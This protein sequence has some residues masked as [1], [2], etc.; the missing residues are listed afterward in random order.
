VIFGPDG[1][2]VLDF[3]ISSIADTTSLTNTGAFVGTV[4]WISPEQIDS[5]ES[6]YTTDV[7]NLGL[8][9][10]YL[11]TGQHAFGSGRSDAVMYRICHSE[12]ETSRIPSPL[13]ELVERCLAKDPLLRPTIDQLTRFIDSSGR[14]W[15]DI[16]LVENGFLGETST[17]SSS[18]AEEAIPNVNPEI[19][20]TVQVSRK[21]DHAIQVS[22]S[23]ADQV[24]TTGVGSIRFFPVRYI[25]GG[26]SVC[27]VLIIS[28]I[29]AFSLNDND[30]P[31]A[32]APLVNNL[33]TA[34]EEISVEV[35]QDEPVPSSIIQYPPLEYQGMN[36][37]ISAAPVAEDPIIQEVFPGP[38]PAEYEYGTCNPES[39]RQYF[40]KAP[41]GPLGCSGAWAVTRINKCPPE[42]ECEGVDIFRWTDNGWI[43]RGFYYSLCVLEIDKSGLP[44]YI[45]DQFLP[46]NQE[47]RSMI[48]YEPESTDGPLELG[49]TGNRVLLIQ[50]RLIEWQL[51][52]DI[53]DSKYGANTQ[54]AITDFQYLAGL[55]PTGVVD[56]RTALALDLSIF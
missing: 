31:E 48:R 14:T 29:L 47:C 9:I 37:D 36:D 41:Q 19:A 18:A 27:L 26:L 38:F 32:L 42:T 4:A 21:V 20:K 40:G 46:G 54:N 24:P 55:E 11:A 50:E 44:R 52:N 35:P 3:G 23:Q 51:L 10:G 8:V 56:E 34:G 2:K 28:L 13:R 30:Q 53:A 25:A 5:G 16:E 15:N 45:N 33:P 6:N 49:D 1:V 7:F 39:I 22:P 43:H 17:A 12:P